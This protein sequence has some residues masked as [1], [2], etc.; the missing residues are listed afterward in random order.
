MS[1]MCARVVAWRSQGSVMGTWRDR[2]YGSL[3]F[4]PLYPAVRALGPVLSDVLLMFAQPAGRPAALCF[5]VCVIAVRVLVNQ[6]E[7]IRLCGGERQSLGGRLCQ[8]GHE[9]SG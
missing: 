6:S 9:Y 7:G 3:L 1:Y 8:V 2:V 4:L 5:S